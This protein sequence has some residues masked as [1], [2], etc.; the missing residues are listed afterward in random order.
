MVTYD[1]WHVTCDMCSNNFGIWVENWGRG[2][3]KSKR[4]GQFLPYFCELWHKKVSIIFL[5]PM[6]KWP[7]SSK[8]PGGGLTWFLKY[9]KSSMSVC[10][11][12]LFLIL[13]ISYLVFQLFNWQI[14]FLHYL[15][16]LSPHSIHLFI[17]LFWRK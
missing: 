1:M 13:F 12:F 4:F 6:E 17:C 14:M 2:L 9:P 10:K 15:H 7:K 8:I 11:S 3:T 5:K 16:Y